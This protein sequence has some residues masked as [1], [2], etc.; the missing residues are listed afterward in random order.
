MKTPLFSSETIKILPILLLLALAHFFVDSM[1]GIWPVY[2]SLAG[3][4]IGTAG[5]IVGVSA[6]I[7]E[8]SQ[9]F[10]GNL[11]D[12]GYRK[13]LII[14]GLIIATS[15]AFLSYTT[16]YGYLFG[17]FL[18]TCIGS[19]CFHPSAASL[20]TS[21]IP[22]RRSL[23]MAIF[24]AGGSIGFATSQLNYATFT[25]HFDEKFYL[26]A[27]PA[28]VLACILLFIPFSPNKKVE[29][30][31]NHSL[32]KNFSDFFRDPSLRA[33][34]L[35]QIA[36]QSIMWATIFILPDVLKEL[37]HS[38]WIC[39]GGGH[40]CFIS[41]AACI[42]IPSG[43]FADKYSG[44][45]ILLTGAIFSSILFYLIILFGALSV[46]VL[47]PLLFLLGSTLGSMNPI[48]VAL[49]NRLEPTRSGAVSAFLMGL[50]WCISETLGPGGVGL[51]SSYFSDGEFASLKALSIIGVLF[52]LQI[53]GALVIPKE[54]T[55]ASKID[56]QALP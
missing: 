41:G 34:Y 32:L 50:V 18:L 29:T 31:Q 3:L 11:S 12:K 48:A 26:L 4:D 43:Y 49:G 22:A 23:L 8:G 40:F 35:S 39:Y 45:T 33:I 56:I 53:Y 19:G 9:L 52:I 25:A 28:I 27:I 42:L 38:E 55:E 24:A 44:R 47:I 37:K 5:L 7:G 1:L 6:F 30:T 54:T 36:N 20:V 2:K 17:L 16:H 21:L 10:F 51:L 14:G 46:T 13:H 15:S